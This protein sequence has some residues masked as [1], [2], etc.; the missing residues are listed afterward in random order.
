MIERRHLAGSCGPVETRG[1]TGL[2]VTVPDLVVCPVGVGRDEVGDGLSPER[3]CHVD[4]W[5]HHWP[6][7]VEWRWGK[8]AYLGT[9][10]TS[11]SPTENRKSKRVV[12]PRGLLT[13]SEN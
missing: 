6:A 11:P 3:F 7:V 9:R 2:V 10:S 1:S 12:G 8:G 13:E 4:P 5:Y